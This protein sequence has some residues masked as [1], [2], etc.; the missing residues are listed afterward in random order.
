[1]KKLTKLTTKLIFVVLL[2]LILGACDKKNKDPMSFKLL[3][4]DTYEVVSFNKNT[5]PEEVVIPEVYNKKAVT[6]I[7]SVAFSGAKEM[8]SVVIPGSVKTIKEEAFS[9]TVALSSVTFKENSELTS[10]GNRAF[11]GATSLNEIT[12]PNSVSEIGSFAFAETGLATFIFPDSLTSISASLFS[13]VETLKQITISKNIETINKD[14]FANLTNLEK[15]EVETGNLNFS[16]EQGVLYNSSK[17]ELIKYPEGKVGLSFTIPSS[18]VTIKQKAFKAVKGLKNLTIPSSVKT[19]ENYA[20]EGTK[21]LESVIVPNSVTSFGE[22]VFKEA[23]GLVSATLPDNLTSLPYM[24]FYGATKLANVSLPDTL[25]YIEAYAFAQT[26]NLN[27]VSLPEN[28]K[29]IGNYAF[30]N[31]NKIKN[32]IIPASVTKIA[33]AALANMASLNKV[34]FAENNNLKIIGNKALANNEAL[35]E[36]EIPATVEIIGESAFAGLT[37]LTTIT[38]PFIG[39]KADATG[40]KAQFAYIFGT[41]KFKDSYEV[42]YSGSISVKFYVPNK[43]KEVIILSGTEIKPNAFDG[44]KEVEFIVLP[45]ELKTISTSAFKNMSSLKEL[46]I[47]DGVETIAKGA[48][49]GTSKLEKITVPFIG[50]SLNSNKEAHQ[51]GYIFGEDKFSGSYAVDY[52]DFIEDKYFYLP[53]T[54]TEVVVLGGSITDYAFSGAEKIEY[55]VIPNDLEVLGDYAFNGMTNLK[56]IELPANLL[57]FGKN[58]LAGAKSLK[59][60]TVP[61]TI[62]VIEE[63]FLQNASALELVVIHDGVEKI[64]KHA[65]DGLTSIKFFDIPETVT[66]I[67]EYAFKGLSNL[68]AITVPISVAKMGEGVFNTATQAVIYVEANEK[69][70]A[71]LSSWNNSSRPV[72]YGVTEET[73]FEKDGVIYVLVDDYLVA[74]RFVGNQEEVFI[75]DIEGVAVKEIGAFAFYGASKLLK[76]KLPDSLERIGVSAFNGAAKLQVINIPLSVEVIGNTAFNGTANLITYVEAD[77]KGAGWHERWI[78]TGRP[79]HYG[80]SADDIIV[81]DNTHYIIKNDVAIL[82]RHLGGFANVVIPREV[83]GYP[84]VTIS[85]S[86]FTDIPEI[87]SLYIP[88]NILNIGLAA[89]YIVDSLVLYAEADK[90][91]T[92]WENRWNLANRPIYYGVSEESFIEKDGAQYVLVNDYLVLTRYSGLA[93]SF[94]VPREVNGHKVKEIKADAF[95]YLPNLKTLFILDNIEK[96]DAGILKQSSGVVVYVEHKSKPAGWNNSWNSGQ[97]I[98]YFE[99]S[100]DSL[101]VKDN[102]HYLVGTNNQ[103]TITRYLGEDESLEI[104]IKVDEKEV[105]TI[106]K[107]AFNGATTLEYIIVHSGVSRVEE[108]AFSGDLQVI[109]YIDIDVLPY[110][111]NAKWNEAEIYYYLKG[112]W[113]LVEGIPVPIVED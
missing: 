11:Y 82:T 79:I 28:L 4:D 42:V 38:I 111:W 7:G 73:S 67:E 15:I 63:G 31:S 46:I 97:N 51:F 41:S 75:D 21:L 109:L 48:L 112:T 104:P 23:V 62:K 8:T 25:E 61:S 99:V 50:S 85:G 87:Y 86:A 45:E 108:G 110:T 32:L 84:L 95:S 65:F 36:L 14:A 98:V 12:L 16:S 88:D 68:I 30:Y 13:G 33:D 60:I 10:V 44:V 64:G 35:K 43:L 92:G 19:I 78:P 80:V 94:V 29:E 37:N 105:K 102:I 72:Y 47:P 90:A 52:Y 91:L 2:M 17:T 101:I 66:T 113:E 69:P 56:E 22:S 77:A 81:I 83:N 27:L 96:V 20:F 9:G 103:L 55:I 89:F 57:S 1:M 53:E 49:T 71:W 59:E 39:A 18:V 107:Q 54:L 76:V 34:T 26:T 58:L 24:T 70:A 6:S 40:N 5:L 106:A 93:N 100:E 74:T 3:D